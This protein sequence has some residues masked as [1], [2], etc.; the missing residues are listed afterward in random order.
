METPKVHRRAARRRAL[1]CVF[2]LSFQKSENTEQ[3]RRTFSTLPVDDD[4]PDEGNES[5]KAG[6][7]EVGSPKETTPQ[8]PL[9]EDQEFGLGL[10]TGVFG[11]LDEID[12]VIRRFSKH[13]KIE[14]IAKAELSILRLGVYELLYE[15]DIPLRVSI[16]EAVEL[17]KE[18]ADDNSFP[19]VNG[20]LDAVARAVSHGEFGIRKQF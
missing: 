11:R 8:T 7:C 17:S 4:A 13:W 19:F 20:I 3:V 14:R 10:V 9:P 6:K 2:A 15:P 18:F 1:Q 16:N 5:G 12:A